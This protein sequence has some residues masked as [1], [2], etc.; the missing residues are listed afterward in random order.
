MGTNNIGSDVV[1]VLSAVAPWLTAAATGGPI[2]LA[3]KAVSS[4][5]GVLGV[6][7]T[8]TT[9]I[10]T[11]LGG[12]MTPD[13][14]LALEQAENT[15]KLQMLAAG[16]ADKEAMAKMDLD[17]I[18]A[19]NATM[20][21]ELSNSDK[22]T[23]LQKSWRPLC[24]LSVAGGSFVVTCLSCLIFY[25][26]VIEG[27]TAALTMLPQLATSVALVLSVPGAAVGI[28]AWH[29][30]VSDVQGAIAAAGGAASK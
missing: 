9:A 29:K 5:A 22:E 3:A 25:K 13:Q 21:S 11:I 1:G 20:A 12:G 17:Q 24:G 23:W 7:P 28:I 30:G 4:I 2:G 15:F 27:Q 18:A 26:A 14:K 10:S 8:D 16:Y 6:S 19:V